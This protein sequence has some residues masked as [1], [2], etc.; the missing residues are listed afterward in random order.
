M[1]LGPFPRLSYRGEGAGNRAR[2]VPKRG[3]PSAG[4]TRRVVAQLVA[5]WSGGRPGGSRMNGLAGCCPTIF[6]AGIVAITDKCNMQSTA[7][8]FER[9]RAGL[10]ESLTVTGCHCHGTVV[11]SVVHSTTVKLRAEGM[12]Q[13]KLNTI[14]ARLVG[15]AV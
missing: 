11:P 15:I 2:L 9:V 7:I 14:F 4:V 8:E 3:K 10:S 1:T 12:Q 5:S 6:R 13:A